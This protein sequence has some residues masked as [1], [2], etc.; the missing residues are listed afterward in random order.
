VNVYARGAILPV[1][2]QSLNIGSATAGDRID[3]GYF[4]TLNVYLGFSVVDDK[5]TSNL[6][7]DVATRTLGKLGVRWEGFFGN[8]AMNIGTVYTRLVADENLGAD[9]GT[10]INYFTNTYTAILYLGQTGGQ[11]VANTILPVNNG[12]QNLGHYSYRWGTGHINTLYTTALAHPDSGSISSSAAFIPAT[13]GGYSLGTAGAYWGSAYINSVFAASGV[14]SEGPVSGT[15]GTFAGTLLLPGFSGSHG[16]E[17]EWE[18]A[19]GGTWS[20]WIVLYS[21]CESSYSVGLYTQY[22]TK[23]GGIVPIVVNGQVLIGEGY[24]AH[25]DNNVSAIHGVNGV[26]NRGFITLRFSDVDYVV[27]VWYWSDMESP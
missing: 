4:D 13:P 9:L 8:L 20:P 25:H 3:N 21:D 11:G 15:T 12:S 24:Q 27:P 18:W 26:V 16:R 2:S 22:W 17:L 23:F 5:V 19:E 14:D 1:S 6:I 7:P 10:S